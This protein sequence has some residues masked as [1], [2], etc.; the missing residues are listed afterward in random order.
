MMKLDNWLSNVVGI[1]VALACTALVLCILFE[2]GDLLP[3]L[4]WALIAFAL[5]SGVT[6]WWYDNQRRK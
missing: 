5:T 3:W 1:V 6:L 2:F 4:L